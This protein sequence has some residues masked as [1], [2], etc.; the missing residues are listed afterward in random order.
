[1]KFIII[2]VSLFLLS[3]SSSAQKEYSIK[4]PPDGQPRDS[5]QQNNRPK[6]GKANGIVID[7]TTKLPVEFATIAVVKIKDNS[8]VT[9]GITNEKG[10]FKIDQIPFGQ[11]KLRITFIGYTTIETDPF[12]IKPPDNFEF[13]AGKISLNPA[14][15]KLA[16]VTF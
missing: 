13:N 1:M 2:A 10:Q 5:T 15:G 4:R 12:F 8:V 11:F 7:P 6:P 16:E 14:T 3:I 9:G